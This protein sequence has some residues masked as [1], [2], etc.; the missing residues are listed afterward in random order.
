M[1]RAVPALTGAPVRLSFDVGL[2]FWDRLRVL[3]GAPVHVAVDAQ[4]AHVG[5]ALEVTV[6][7]KG[8]RPN[9][10]ID[11]QRTMQLQ[12]KKGAKRPCR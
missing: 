7:V 2:G 5:V 1:G 6:V 12:K 8:R 4:P 10:T 11:A 9:V 3:F